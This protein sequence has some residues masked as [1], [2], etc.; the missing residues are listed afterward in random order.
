MDVEA[1]ELTAE[2]IG[3]PVF[4][5]DGEEVG[6]VTDLLLDDSGL[7]QK[8]RFTTGTHLG[9]GGRTL[10]VPG[11]AFMSLRGAAVLDFPAADVAFLPEMQDG[12]E[13]R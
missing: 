8:L 1:T 2:L 4:G 5:I 12:D 9:I 10:E 7:P 6:T 11:S 3:R 13:D